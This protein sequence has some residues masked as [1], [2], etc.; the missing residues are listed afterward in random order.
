MD[1]KKAPAAEC[2]QGQLDGDWLKEEEGC[3][4]TIVCSGSD[5]DVVGECK[6]LG[7]DRDNWLNWKTNAEAS[8]QEWTSSLISWGGFD[9]SRIN[10]SHSVAASDLYFGVVDLGI[11]TNSWFGELLAAGMTKLKLHFHTGQTEQA[12][13]AS[14]HKDCWRKSLLP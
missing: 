7:V 4:A 11:T 1:W 2:E 12:D 5:V 8:S 13:S 6:Y 10:L 3:S 9:F 14:S